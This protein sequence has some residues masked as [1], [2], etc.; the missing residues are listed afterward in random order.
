[1]DTI[2]VNLVDTDYSPYEWQTVASRL[3]WSMGNAVVQAAGVVRRRI[4]DLVAEVWDELPEDLTIIDGKVISFKSER[5]VELKDF[6]VTGMQ[7]PDGSWRGGPILGEGSFM[8]TYVSGLDPET[9]QGE[10]AVVHWTTGA[11]AVE[12]EVN[13]ETGEIEVLKASAAYDVGKAINPDLVLTQI[14]GGVVQGMS[15]ALFEELKLEK[16]QP[17]NACLADYK[18]ATAVDAPAEIKGHIVEVPQDDGPWGARGVGEHTMVPTAPAIANAVYDAL[19]VR[20]TSLPL[21]AEKVYLAL[22]EK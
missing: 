2:R 1:M 8:P 22:Q 7:M 10:R 13:T 15:T 3:T 9:G 20:I 18:I 17:T 16:G 4:L 14:E 21:T 5:E 11:Q 12:V 6:A 19:R